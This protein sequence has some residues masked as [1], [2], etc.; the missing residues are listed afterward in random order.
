[1]SPDLHPVHFADDVHLSGAFEPVDGELP[2]DLRGAYVRNGPNPKFEP[3][4]YTYPLDGDGMLHGIWIDDDGAR[5]RNRYVMTKALAAEV[6]AGKALWG[7]VMDP[8][9]PPPELAGPDPDPEGKLLPDIHVVRHAGRYLALAEATPPYEVTADLETVGRYDFG[10]A[11]APGMCAHPK[12]DPVTGEMVVFRY[13]L[14]EPFLSWAVVGPDGTVTHELD[15]IPGVDR[16]YMIHDFVVTEDHLVLFLNPATIDIERAMKGESPLAW[17][18][19]LGTR[20]AVIPR[21]GTSADVRWIETD[22]FWCWHW[23]N[24]WQEGDEIVTGFSWWSDFSFGRRAQPP[25]GEVRTAR[26]DPVKGTYR[27]ETLDDRMT[28]FAR[29]DERRQTRRTR[30][31]TV[32]WKSP[33]ARAAGMPVGSFDTLV[34]YDLE[35]GTAAT[36]RFD[37]Q[38]LGE[39]VFAPKLGSDDEDAGYVVTFVTDLASMESRFV[40]LDTDDIAA[41]PVATVRLPRRVP[42]GLHGSWFPAT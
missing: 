38:A 40:V 20:I 6:R 15:V 21:S 3:L 12:I 26:I 8:V 2:D 18:P 29:V 32:S 24:G 16:C 17:E 25:T 28:D 9:A 13:D 23:A 11:L 7:G 10:G 35:R 1:M 39:A 14:V 22:P 4:S 42:L 30:Y 31:F 41:P 19:D 33:E 5:Y 36:H 34:R 37:G 27:T